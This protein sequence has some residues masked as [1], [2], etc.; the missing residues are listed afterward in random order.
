MAGAPAGA[1]GVPAGEE[2]APRRTA[3]RRSVAGLKANARFRQG[4]QVWRL[5]FVG[6]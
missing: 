1:E 4:I 6:I 2:Q 5:R 3:K